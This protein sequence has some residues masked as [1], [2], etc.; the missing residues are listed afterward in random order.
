[1]LRE[2]RIRNLA[3]IEELRLGFDDGLNILTGETGAGKS[4]ILG[5]LR[6]VLGER[7][8]AD[9]VRTGAEAAEAEALFEAPLPAS[10][11]QLLE[12]AGLAPDPE[13]LII[14]RE[15]AADGR[16]RAFVNGRLA[17]AHQLRDLGALLIDLHGQH[18]HQSLLNPDNHLA[19]LDSFADVQAELDA[20]AETYDA[21][22]GARA[23]L[24][25][26]QGDERALEREKDMLEHQ[27][28]EIE[29]AA[30][31]PGEDE[32]L[33]LE[34]ARLANAE[35][36]RECA[37]RAFALLQEGEGDVPSLLEM[38]ARVETDVADLAKLDESERP[39]AEAAGEIRF[40]LEDL[41]ARMRDY[42]QRAES[43]PA[44]LSAVEDRLDLIRR[45]KR[46]YGATIEE[47]LDAG[48][49]C[50]Q[51]LNSL[52]HREDEIARLEQRLAEAER[53]LVEAAEALSAK[54]QK[55][56]RAFERK[57]QGELAELQMERARFSVQFWRENSAEGA[58]FAEGRFAVGP[59][60]VD[61]V[62][63]L[64]TTNP[65]EA[66]KPLRRI[67][68]G[69]ELSRIMLGIK[70]LLARRD[71]IPT[72]V[73]D[74]IDVGISGATAQ[75]VGAKMRRLAESHQVLCITHLPQIAA[76]AAR[77]FSVEKVPR[78]KRVATQVRQL[79]EHER[80]EEIARLLGGDAAS[81]VGLKHAQELLAQCRAPH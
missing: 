50:S 37:A 41:A 7:A 57:L 34:R 63:F 30:L 27:A 43:D 59:R 35:R 55:A 21:W 33:A 46:K 14:R 6:L 69:G 1:M 15:V 67:A 19:A 64:M 52:A 36:L 74:E 4:I 58:A 61:R 29:Q 79:G 77:H 62:E 53:R 28:R 72:L 17:P 2:L 10:A 22:T 42:A 54:R 65:G 13:G 23:E 9:D 68:S 51:R 76:R 32:E 20:M 48:A 70:S 25:Q 60:G 45:L 26:L 5:A 71:A 12:E 73:F 49:R 18:Q 16:S 31:R 78:G 8:A 40:R 24:A 39:T 81:A 66:L 3:I 47:I 38:L 44:R 11:L 75:V 80:V 56:A